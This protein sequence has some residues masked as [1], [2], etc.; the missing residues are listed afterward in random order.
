MHYALYEFKICIL[1]LT[2]KNAMAVETV[3]RFVRVR[4]I[5]SKRT[6]PILSTL[7]IASNAGLA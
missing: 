6:D 4:S 3:L 5:K 7:R 1:L 2:K